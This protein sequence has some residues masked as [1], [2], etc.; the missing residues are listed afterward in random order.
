MAT[1]IQLT[2]TANMPPVTT[3]T[4]GTTSSTE[5][6][7]IVPSP[8][9]VEAAANEAGAQDAVTLAE[10]SVGV[11]AAAELA[12][13]ATAKDELAAHAEAQAKERQT[14]IDARKPFL[15]EAK[16]KADAAEDAVSNHQFYDYWSTKSTGDRIVS[17]LAKGLV[18]F[19]NAGLH[20]Q[21]NEI[22]DK[23]QQE[24]AQDFAK[25]KAQLYTKEKIAEWRRTGVKDMYGQLQ[26]ELAALGVK[27]AKA[28]EAVAAKAEA[29]VL[30]A[31]AP[32][33]IAKQN[34]VSA[35]SNVTAAGL[36][37]ESEQ[38][39]EQKAA[40]SAG[41]NAGV[42]TTS[43]KPGAGGGVEADKNAANF[44]VLKEHGGRIA[45]AMPGLS[46]DDVA[47]VNRVMNSEDFLDGKPLLTTVGT[48]LGVDPET[49]VSP[50]AKAYLMD[51]RAASEGLGR[52]QSGAA[53]GSVENKRFVR[54]L[55]PQ[56]SDTPNDR[57]MRADNVVKDIELRGA[58]MARP[59]RNAAGGEPAPLPAGLPA[60]AKLVGKTKSGKDAYRLPNG[61]LV[62]Q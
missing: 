60:G 11:T 17:R 44:D 33:E 26:E 20:I 19:A 58:H 35:K 14:L 45:K 43:A 51:V 48:A 32:L 29:M 1:D 55:M 13:K 47:A 25:Q 57:K 9:A 8:A 42:S 10:N 46:S 36:R 62:T 40:R 30:R 53:I 23:I 15:D 24:V 39:Y 18:A 27:Q 38:R 21:G 49:G 52:V 37:K 12:A 6:S 2:P 31:G 16:S 22:A 59:A 50:A 5:R 4:D 7:G 34:V 41:Q 28:H 61:K 3:V 56:I 54:A